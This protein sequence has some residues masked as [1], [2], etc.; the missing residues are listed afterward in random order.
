MLYLIRDDNSYFSNFLCP[1]PFICWKS[2]KKSRSSLKM[3]WPTVCTGKSTSFLTVVLC[4][5]LIPQ[6]YGGHWPY[7]FNL[8]GSKQGIWRSKFS[9]NLRKNFLLS[10]LLINPAYVPS[11]FPLPAGTLSQAV[12]PLKTFPK[13]KNKIA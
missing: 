4:L 6:N 2:S 8:N 3:C 1:F 13:H 9:I 12:C 11:V 7:N 10:S 5:S